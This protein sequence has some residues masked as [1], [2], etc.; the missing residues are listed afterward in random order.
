MIG[1]YAFEISTTAGYT[2]PVTICVDLDDPGVQSRAFR[3]S[4]LPA[5][6]HNENGVLVN[7]TTSYDAQTEILC[8]QANSFSPFVVAE[9]VYPAASSTS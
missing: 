7:I 9:Q 4:G 3:V 6:M 5:L 8:G 1:N 2:P